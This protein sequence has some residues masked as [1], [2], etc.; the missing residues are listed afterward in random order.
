MKHLARLVMGK[1][2]PSAVSA[3]FSPRTVIFDFDG[4]IGDTFE[5]GFEILNLLA[6]EFGFRTIPRADIPRVRAMRTHEMLSYL[7][8]STAKLPALSK[9]GSAELALRMD[10][11]Q[12]LPGL[13][14]A[15]Q[16]LASRG[17]LLGIITSNTEANVRT[18]LENHALDQFGFIRSSSK[19][20]GKA[21]EIRAA[22]KKLGLEGHEVLYVGDETRDIEACKKAGVPIAAVTWGYSAAQALAALNPEFL[23]HSPDELLSLTPPL[24]ENPL[25]A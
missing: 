11:I 8:V 9:R 1:Q 6:A 2:R 14:E 12:P 16:E 5:A 10:S 3:V 22:L 18:F 25:S 23:V 24:D 20:F 15:I 4:T 17:Y 21:R 7:G 19:L 13:Q